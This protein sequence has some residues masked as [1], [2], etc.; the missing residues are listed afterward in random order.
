[1]KD[2]VCVGET[3]ALVTPDP[4]VSLAL[5]GPARLDAAGAEST[6]AC[7]LAQLGLD[8]AWVS[9]LGDDPLGELVR[10]TVAG[11]GVDVSPVTV[12]PDRP[13]G[14]FFKD[15]DGEKTRVFYVRAGSAASAMSPAMNVPEARITHLSGITAALSASCAA[16]V[17]HLL[18]TRRCGFDVNYRPRLW[19]VG[20]AAPVLRGLAARAAVVFVGLDEALTLWDT[21]TPDEVRALLPEPEILVVKDGAVGAT[22]FHPGGVT[23]APAPRVDVV[24]A[25]GAGDAFAAGYLAGLLR[26]LG[27]PDRLCL[28]HRTAGAAL[29]T[30]GDVA[31]LREEH[32]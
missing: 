5:G 18:T 31:T 9:R 19:P 8:A 6:V 16:L 27:E 2:V 20:R 26:D 1:M 32:A 30:T 3:M 7:Y 25:V 11:F 12:D 10:G 17:E 14:V 22:S 29:R 24:E 23:F 21:R 13:T 28:G 15:P 4:P